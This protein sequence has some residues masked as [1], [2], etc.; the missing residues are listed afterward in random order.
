M[1]R[2]S[3]FVLTF[4]S[5]LLT[6]LP[7]MAGQLV[8]WNFN[9][10]QNR[11][12]FYT[13]SRVQPTAQLIPNPTR[14][15]VDLP[16]TTLSG[17]TVR[18]PAGG[19]V[20]EIRIGE[21]DSFT[22]RVVI[23]LD[24]GYTVDPQK[25]KVRGITPT[26][27]V[28]ELPTPELVPANTTPPP[29]Q[30]TAP[31]GPQSGLP[32]TNNPNVQVTASG[33]FVRLDKNGSNNQLRMKSNSRQ[34]TLEFELGGAVLPEGL[35]GQSFP[36]NQFGVSEIQ[37]S[38]K[39]SD[40]RL[41]L[42]LQESGV[43][44]NAYYSRVGGGIVLLPKS[45][46]RSQGS[47]PSRPE[48]FSASTGSP[49][50]DRVPPDSA[51]S[52][53]S[54]TTVVQ[55]QRFSS[56]NLATITAIDIT[57]DDSQ[58][59]I[60]GDRQITARG[61][62]NRLTG[63][64]EV[65]IDRAQLAQQFQSPKLE[66]NGP[67]Y[68]LNIRQETP[69]TVLVIVQANAGRRF[70]RLFRSGGTLYALELIP[71]ATANRPGPR[72]GQPPQSGGNIPIA[73]I[74][75]PPGSQPSLPPNINN[76]SLPPANLPRVP[77]GSR[78]V[79]ID[80]GHGGKDPGAIG[81][82]GVQEKDVIMPI[83]RYVAEY[84][85]QQGVRVLMARTSDYFVSLQGRTDMANRAGADLFV[86]IHANSM[87]KGR[88]DVSGFEIY[89]FG[90]PGLSQ[91]IHRNVIRSVDVKDRGVRKARFYVLR[92]SRMPSTLVETGFVTGYE[93]NAK[94][95]NPAYQKQMAQAIAR[96]ILEYLQQR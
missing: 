69:D 90:S 92:N 51:S 34:K 5:V 39:E 56:G 86:S 65:R 89:Y 88:P 27:W 47:Q 40:P 9:A 22:T 7:A 84:L 4:L 12:T 96:G 87:G 42:A 94:L 64:Y 15:V 10:A 68:Q 20:K 24:A 71:D 72:P 80:P 54:T 76:P 52:G 60:R 11:F 25:V 78:L 37:F 85:E 43:S 70:G 26:Q 29:P 67:I 17:P 28:V 1:S 77:Q 53:S 93:D 31:M 21:P 83:S 13:N 36:I 35:K 44:W 16:G 8:N 95:T 38:D 63:N 23:E 46:S 91:A 59:L 73:I 62:L 6:S 30:N 55:S 75:P 74:P 57:R 48:S 50:L 82:G 79:F 49:A 66:A 14:I 3:G 45:D 61:T 18:Q 32:A 41:S 81:L 2:L 33:L 58:L 19:K